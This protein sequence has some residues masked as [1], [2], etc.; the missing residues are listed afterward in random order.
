MKRI[1]NSNPIYKLD[2]NNDSEISLKELEE[3]IIKLTSED[4]DSLSKDILNN[5]E[6]RYDFFQPVPVLYSGLY[7]NL[8]TL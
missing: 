3:N 7:E 2:A 4:L 5:V 6:G 1:S 8:L